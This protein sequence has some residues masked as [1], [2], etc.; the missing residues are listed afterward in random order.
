MFFALVGTFDLIS[1]QA[2]LAPLCEVHEACCT[3]LITAI[4]PPS[5]LF[6]LGEIRV[7]RR[8]L[9]IPYWSK[10]T[11]GVQIK[12]DMY[13]QVYFFPACFFPRL[14]PP[15][16]TALLFAKKRGQRQCIGGGNV[17][18]GVI[19]K[20]NISKFPNGR[21]GEPPRPNRGCIRMRYCKFVAAAFFWK[22]E[23]EMPPER[24]PLRVMSCPCNGALAARPPC[25]SSDIFLLC[26]VE[27]DI[28]DAYT[29]DA[30]GLHG[31]VVIL[32]YTKQRLVVARYEMPPERRPRS[33][34]APAA[35]RLQHVPP[36]FLPVLALRV[37][38]CVYKRMLSFYN[39]H[40]VIPVT[41][42]EIP[43][44]RPHAM[45]RLIPG[46]MHGVPPAFLPTLGRV[47]ATLCVRRDALG[48]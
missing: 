16:C 38:F 25:I 44:P 24:R 9:L 32:R 8:F 3:L 35:V 14:S 1:G 7:Y 13:H 18:G 31:F 47:A 45:S 11:G 43:L 19:G 46:A 17:G 5:S 42:Y 41:E 2:M 36:A 37:L 21:E 20:T 23:Y 48:L 6:F 4:P 12:E 22:V 15:A 34:R 27:A 39:A 40:R 29:R 10:R 30:L 33:C 26:W 28:L